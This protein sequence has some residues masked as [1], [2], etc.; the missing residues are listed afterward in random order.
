M[1]NIFTTPILFVIF[2]RPDTTFRVFEAIRTAKPTKLFVAADGPR[3]DRP[4]DEE[5]CRQARTVL[6]K[7]DW[8]CEVKTLFREKNLGCKLGVSSAID[9]FFENVEEG[10]ILEDDCL[11]DPSFF[12]FCQDLLGYYRNDEKVMHISGDNF[13]FGKKYGDGSYYFSRYPHIWGWATWRRAWKKYDVD[14]KSFPQ[15]RKENG[16]SR[17]F[18]DKGQQRYWYKVLET[19]Y[20]GQVDT[21]D[22]QWSY[23]VWSNGGLAVLPNQNLIANIGFGPE[24]THTKTESVLAN[25]TQGSAGEMVHPASQEVAA[26]ADNQTFERIYKTSFFKKVLFKLKSFLGR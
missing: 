8:P 19:M 11:P 22:H 16:L 25:L 5:K 18:N 3:K 9:W 6:D 4:G 17:V 14:I 1:E 10:I 24:A 13:Q 12:I 23:A 26:E 21:W 2:N 20:A 7:I 15:F